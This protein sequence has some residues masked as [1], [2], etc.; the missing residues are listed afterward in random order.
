MSAEQT[1]KWPDPSSDDG[2]RRIVLCP[3]CGWWEKAEHT[4]GDGQPCEVSDDPETWCAGTCEVREVRVVPTSIATVVTD[5]S[6]CG[7]C[8]GSGRV[9]DYGYPTR[10][11]QC[12]TARADDYVRLDPIMEDE[13]GRN[14]P[15]VNPNARAGDDR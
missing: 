10:C 13:K 4:I 3:E 14:V 9:G 11:P 6:M 1:E 15:Y 12:A 7:M 2:V 8:G 5:P